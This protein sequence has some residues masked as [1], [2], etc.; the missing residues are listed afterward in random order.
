LGSGACCRRSAQ[1]GFFGEGAGSNRMS[2][3][4]V[5]VSSHGTDVMGNRC[6]PVGVVSRCVSVADTSLSLSLSLCRGSSSGQDA[7]FGARNGAQNNLLG[8][9]R[10]A[11]ERGFRR[12]AHGPAA[13]ASFT[14]ACVDHKL[15]R[16]PHNPWSSFEEAPSRAL[17]PRAGVAGPMRC[18]LNLRP[19]RSLFRTTM[20]G[21][22]FGEVCSSVVAVDP[23]PAVA[24]EEAPSRAL[25][26]RAGVV[27]HVVPE[28]RG[29][30]DPR[31]RRSPWA[32]MGGASRRPRSLV[33][34]AHVARCVLL[35]PRRPGRF[36][37]GGGR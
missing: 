15:G 35:A 37:V 34:R 1:S 13:A 24:F 19:R 9:A 23:S 10:R 16:A 12:P 31:P 21:G 33:C 29:P 17:F 11:S 28:R 36:L 4:E 26:P 14:C 6:A 20:A 8:T 2:G 5:R 30:V 22:R 32:A 18:G 7:R 3:N 27:V 25:L